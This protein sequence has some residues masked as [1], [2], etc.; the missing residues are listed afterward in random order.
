MYEFL[1][2]W[3]FLLLPV[4]FAVRWLLKPQ[5]QRVGVALTVPFLEDFQQSATFRV[6]GRRKSLLLLAT[7]AWSLLVAAAARPIWVENSIALPTSGRDLMLA[8]D[9]SG[10]MQEQDF[11]LNGQV[12]DRLVAT[13]AV[14]A[15]FIRQREGDRLG[16]IL[17]ADRAYLQV[18]LTF[19]RTTVLRL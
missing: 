18:P 16:L 3:M 7:L 10:S 9:L 8:V 15:D 19:D 2:W 6:A 5:E 17:F 4:P 11:I 1:W 14:A 13:K 12:V